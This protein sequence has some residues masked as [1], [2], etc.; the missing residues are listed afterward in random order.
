[1]ISF[2]IPAYNEEAL[3]GRTVATLR[4][5][6]TLALDG[7]PFEIIVV[8]DASSDRTGAI[9]REH[10]A[11]VVDVE[12]RQ[13]AAV[14]N[15]G[16]KAAHGEVLIFVDADTLVPAEAVRGAMNAL[17]TGAVAGGSDVRFD[18]GISLMTRAFTFL[19]I[20]S[21]MLTRTAA[22]CFI[23]AQR[24]AFESAGGFDERFFAGEEVLMSQALKRQGRFEM[25]KH[26]VTTSGR[27][28]RMHGLLNL[29]SRSMRIVWEGPQAVQRRE[30]LDLWYDGR[31]E[32]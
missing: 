23:F 17:R 25:V 19:L 11:R 28:V 10:G 21:F 14:R 27:K 32:D 22:G 9:A 6:A 4:A 12:K 3:I 8:D 31:R 5:S 2:I 13:I 18:H 16:A 1:M 29:L 15:A 20:T 30:G 26:A 24:E 7:R